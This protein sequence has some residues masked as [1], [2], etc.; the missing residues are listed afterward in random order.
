MSTKICTR[1]NKEKLNTEEFFRRYTTSEI[2]Q[3]KSGLQVAC[4]ECLTKAHNNW[5][6]NNNLQVNTYNKAYRYKT[7]DWVDTFKD[8]P[9]ADCGVKYPSYVMDFDH[10][11]EH[12]KTMGIPMMI[13]RRAPKSKIL[14]EINKCEVVC[15]NCHRERTKQ[16]G[17]WAGRYSVLN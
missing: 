3:G 1:C 10:L 14:E 17:T 2:N 13:N 12:T 15:S 9:C 4:R 16:R 11:P 8:V 6:K 7:A 5:S